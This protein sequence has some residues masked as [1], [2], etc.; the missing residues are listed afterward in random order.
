MTLKTGTRSKAPVG[1]V[2][3]RMMA[4]KSTNAIAKRPTFSGLRQ[5]ALQIALGRNP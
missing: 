2:Y 1:R 4:A 3:G 5:I